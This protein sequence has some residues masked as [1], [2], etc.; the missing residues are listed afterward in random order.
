MQLFFRFPE[1]RDDRFDTFI[2]DE[3]NREAI[4][5]CEKFALNSGNE[6]GWG[7]LVLFGEKGSGKTHLLSAMGKKVTE[8]GGDALYLDCDLL[9]STIEDALSYDEIKK[10]LA[11]YEK[12]AYLAINGLEKIED[13]VVAQEQVF[14][15][16][17]AIKE[18]GGRMAVS[19]TKKPA[20]WSFADYLSTRL[21]WGQ[22][23][24]LRPVGDDKM[25]YVLIKM[26]KDAG[27]HLPRDAA[28][29]LLTRLPRD[30]E[31]LGVALKRIDRYSL[32][33][34]RKVSIQLVREALEE[35]DAT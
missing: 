22:V 35:K 10:H 17:N 30:P 2:S 7:S 23:V 28:K 6:P 11:K 8:S 9:A 31:S 29:W 3:N 24:E 34:K 1:E 4:A 27:L 33:Q 16:Y 15:L 13:S 12:V 32:T 21:L 26:A 20:R 14:H 5:L 19:V 18:Y 25:V